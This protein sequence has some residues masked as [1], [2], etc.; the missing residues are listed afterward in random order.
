VVADDV[1]N[2]LLTTEVTEL[3]LLSEVGDCVDEETEGLV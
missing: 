2:G 3:A 1:G